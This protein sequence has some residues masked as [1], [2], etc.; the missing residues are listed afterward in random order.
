MK[1][2]SFLI[3][4]V[5]GQFLFLSLAWS[6]GTF[7]DHGKLRYRFSAIHETQYQQLNS[8]PLN[9]DNELVPQPRYNS[10]SSAD[11]FLNWRAF[12]LDIKA[13]ALF[14]EL[15]DA[16]YE[17]TLRELYFGHPLGDHVQVTVGRK[18]LKWG[19]GF[20]FNPTGV[21]EPAKDAGDPSD[22]LNRF[23]GRPIV[24]LDTYWGNHSLTLVY[25]NELKS[26]GRIR[27]AS[28]ELAVKFYS[29]IKD[30]D[31]SLIGHWKEKEKVKFGFN[32]A[33]VYGDHLA[34]HSEF[35]AQVGSN[36]LYHRAL[37]RADHEIFL[38]DSLFT[39]KYQSSKRLFYELLLGMQY[40]FDSG[41]NLMAEYFYD[42]AGLTSDNWSQWRRF[43][44]FHQKQIREL[45]PN[46]ASFPEFYNALNT[47]SPDGAMRHYGFFRAYLPKRKFGLELILLGNLVD[48]SGILIPTF[49]YSFNSHLNGWLRSSYFEGQENSEFGMLFTKTSLEL[50]VK[51]SF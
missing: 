2:K 37:D 3:S 46:E 51:L 6:Q 36:E 20:A 9:V 38:G 25:A 47:L 11:L 1:A 32:T 28:D 23:Q 42:R 21:V 48:R 27:L 8:T 31:V 50:G 33:Y 13:N 40:T 15:E 45:P 4:V 44:L 24:A 41:L 17:Y 5:F 7:K 39:V 26:E 29:F 35:I 16:N 34:L 49:S 10:L 19:T 14:S 30:V 18:I 22:R 43:T 12:T